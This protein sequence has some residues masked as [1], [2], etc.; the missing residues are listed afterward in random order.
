MNFK[1]NLEDDRI[2]IQLLQQDEFNDLY[3]IAKDPKIWEQHP[4]NDRWKID[5]FSIFFNNGIE[6]EF[7]IYKIIDK[8]NNRLIGSSRFYS[9]DQRNKAIRIGFTF[10][11]TEYWGTTTNFRVKKLMIDNAFKYVDKIY[12]D[13]GRNNFRSRRAVEKLGANFCD[14]ASEGMVVYKLD[15]LSFLKSKK[16]ILS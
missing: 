9:F 10:I 12:F 8:K 14:F 15:K 2:K 11:I 6:N 4:E 13:I 16:P 3:A 5:K 7:G 1:L